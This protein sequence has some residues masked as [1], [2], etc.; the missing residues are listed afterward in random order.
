VPEQVPDRTAP[1]LVQ[2]QVLKDVQKAMLN[3]F[4]GHDL[5]QNIRSRLSFT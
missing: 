3:F 5:S 1:R 2:R 4:T